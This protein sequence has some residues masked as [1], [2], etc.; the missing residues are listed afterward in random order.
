M[1][2]R[3][4]TGRDAVLYALAVGAGGIDGEAELA[5]TTEDIDESGQRVLPSFASVLGRRTSDA[6]DPLG[7]VDRSR[8]VHGEQTLRLYAPLPPAGDVEVRSEILEVLEKRTGTLVRV[9]T[10]AVD[11]GTPLFES[12]SGTFLRG[13]MGIGEVRAG[14]GEPWSVPSREPDLT[15]R[16]RVNQ[17]QAL[18]YRLTGDMNPLHASPGVAQRAGFPR[19]ILHGLC[20]YGFACRAL[21][22]LRE[23]AGMS[24]RF[25]APVYPGD[26]LV[27]HVWQDG[28]ELSFVVE[29]ADGVR[30]L[31]R[32][33]AW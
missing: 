11:G 31:D 22:Q 18:L 8:L 25:S 1:E 19:P 3:T 15:V 13:V 12:E 33:T 10:T 6:L 28:A 24:A 9:R 17:E 27:T 21:L 5:Y 26:L 14:G 29:N 30:V 16:Q 23:L 7:D 4:W 20:T 2:R 32:G